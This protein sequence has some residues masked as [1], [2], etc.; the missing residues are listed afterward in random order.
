M[1][2]KLKKQ[3]SDYGII[4]R[5]VTCFILLVIVPFFILALVIAIVFMNYTAS[6]MGTASEDAMNSV[7]TQITNAIKKY[8]WSL[9]MVSHKPDFRRRGKEL[10]YSGTFTEQ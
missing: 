9:F 10:L 1:F 3:F 6:N 5:I 4:A 8:E 2:A 7:G